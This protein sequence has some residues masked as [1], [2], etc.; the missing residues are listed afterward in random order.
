[1]GEHLIKIDMEA[2][3][4]DLT[5]EQSYAWREANDE[6]L[7][8]SALRV[9]KPLPTV[10]A[11]ARL[12]HL[13][14][15]H[16]VLRSRFRV[17]GQGAPL[18]GGP[19]A[20]EKLISVAEPDDETEE[21]LAGRLPGIV[22][23]LDP[24]HGICLS[25]ELLEKSGL[26][27]AI[28]IAAHPLAAD[29]STILHVAGFVAGQSPIDDKRFDALC[30]WLDDDP[31]QGASYPRREGPS[32][33]LDPEPR[34]TGLQLRHMGAPPPGLGPVESLWLISCK[35]FLR[36]RFREPQFP[37][38][39]AVA[40]PAPGR[41]WAGPATRMVATQVHYA[42]LSFMEVLECERNAL[43]A[44]RGLADGAG[45]IGASSQDATI[46]YVDFACLKPG[47]R[48]E[49]MRGGSGFGPLSIKIVHL[50]GQ[51]LL[52]LHRR[53][54]CDPDALKELANGLLRY[55]DSAWSFPE[56][57]WDDNPCISGQAE[58]EVA[59]RSLGP[60]RPYV[61]TPI[62]QGFIT[63]ARARPTAAAV[64]H[65]DTVL[66]FAQVHAATSRL[67]QWICA[68][69]EGPGDPVIGIYTDRGV[70]WPI[71]ALAAWKAGV[72][73]LPMNPR[74]PVAYTARLLEAEGV[75]AVVADALLPLELGQIPMVLLDDMLQDLDG[76]LPTDDPPHATAE[77]S[78]YVITTSGTTGES[79]SVLVRHRNLANLF[80]HFNRDIYRGRY[81][82]Q[83]VIVNAPIWFD[84]AIKQLMMIC[85]GYPLQILPDPARLDPQEFARNLQRAEYSAM[86]VTPSQL[87]Y[88]LP[89]PVARSAI[90]RAKLLLV[91]GE[92][93]TGQLWTSVCEL[94]VEAYNVYGPTENTVDAAIGRIGSD[95]L[96]GVGHPIQNVGMFILDDYRRPL[97]PGSIG[98][99]WLSGDGLAEYRRNGDGSS[100]AV[101]DFLD[102]P[103]IYRTGDRGR[104]REDSSFEILGRRDDQ[105]KVRGNRVD[106]NEIR[107]TILQCE[108]V[109]EA[110]VVPRSVGGEH[111]QLFAFIVPA[112]PESVALNAQP[113][114]IL[115]NGAPVYVH[116]RHEAEFLYREIFDERTRFPDGLALNPGDMVLDIGANIGLVSLG[117]HWAVEGLSIVAVEPIEQVAEILG[118]NL[119]LH[120]VDA[121]IL[122]IAVGDR[123]GWQALSFIPDYSIMTTANQGRDN[124]ALVEAVVRNQAKSGGVAAQ[125]I[126]E[127][128]DS[129]FG[130][131]W[132]SS[133]V[134]VPT[135]RLSTLLRE[136]GNPEVALLKIDVQGL[137]TQVLAGLSDSDW[138][139]IRQL[140]LEVH[141]APRQFGEIQRQLE[142]HGFIVSTSQDA[143]N[144]GTDRLNLFARRA[145]V[146]PSGGALRC[147][148]NHIRSRAISL[149]EIGRHIRNVLPEYMC[150]SKLLLVPRVLVSENGKIDRDA[151]FA[152][153]SPGGAGPTAPL[154]GLELALWEIWSGVLG[155]AAFSVD[156]DFFELGGDSLMQI[157]AAVEGRNRGLELSPYDIFSH[158]TIRS[159]ARALAAEAKP[160]N[161]DV[162]ATRSFDVSDTEIEFIRSQLTGRD[163]Q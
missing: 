56:R 51:H 149:P 78:A 103:R 15:T 8:C 105:L 101:A 114:M 92:I 151:M 10:E 143:F 14:E 18:Q 97:P 162:R 127:D 40:P 79:K 50:D 163:E 119:E 134:S 159:L 77:T 16:D 24:E 64:I 37:V 12:L 29:E 67:A 3:A 125:L 38:G 86:D 59:A 44:V 71:A 110:V 144:A 93:V 90:E 52:F 147:D 123:D 82:D 55:I 148:R 150:P 19:I 83:P 155:H 113:H 132:E 70:G 69:C 28:L 133:L 66:T 126:V 116:R 124:R 94:S 158:P 128:L 7:L 99:V 62:V 22:G 36:A 32:A 153:T 145:D 138:P 33:D 23:R 139:R 98:D 34:P 130:D 121:R 43:E 27:E 84:A 63:E 6:A 104:M 115:P 1:M 74:N 88:L 112:A 89:D 41:N 136:L 49:A 31:V 57:R 161:S 109:R 80:A 2:H 76:A 30:P 65:G 95:V 13:V 72:P 26:C 117:Y 54:G 47:L 106:L 135:R 102:R 120:G 91:G 21:D 9:L 107:R 5:P 46:E 53:D 85:A 108:G 68:R 146:V 81:R 39:F 48:V 156:D 25:V 4:Y 111:Q 141:D 157:R 122:S 61:R 96:P 73:F 100:F 58:H 152:E 60:A 137:E 142:L 17:F 42:E 87:S 160:E 11:R 35:A 75:A 20:A 140:L 131:R 154:Q 129:Y 118:R 45:A